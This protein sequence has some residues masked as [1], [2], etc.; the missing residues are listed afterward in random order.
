MVGVIL[1]VELSRTTEALTVL[2]AK[3]L[4]E[5]GAATAQLTRGSIATTAGG[6]A[7]VKNCQLY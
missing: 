6:A 7:G 3:L 5:L 1:I 4:T 2:W